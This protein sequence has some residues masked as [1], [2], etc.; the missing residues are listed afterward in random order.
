VRPRRHPTKTITVPLKIGI[1][2]IRDYPVY[3][4]KAATRLNAKF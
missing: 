3:D 1:P 2:M 4:F